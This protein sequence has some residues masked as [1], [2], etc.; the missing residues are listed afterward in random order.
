MNNDQGVIYI[1]SMHEMFYDMAVQSANSL[2]DCYN[3][4]S[5]TLFTH[6][7][8]LKKDSEIFDNI[9]THIPASARA[10]MWACARSP[11]KQTLYI[12]SDTL[13]YSDEIIK[14]FDYIDNHDIAFEKLLVGGAGNPA[15]EYAD[16][17]C[18]HRLIHHGG[19]YTWNTSD[20]LVDFFNTWYEEYHIQRYEWPEECKY[21]NEVNRKWDMLTLWRLFHEEKFK[22]FHDLKVNFLDKKFNY[23]PWTP[24]IYNPVI[25]HYPKEHFRDA[26]RNLGK[27]YEEGILK[28]QK[29]DHTAIKYY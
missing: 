7:P 14:I 12:D 22:R 24:L 20:L 11:Y 29:F 21:L 9:I 28:E 6:E 3:N 16:K 1:A 13:I 2:K 27:I 19:I 4:L 8:F 17:K 26:K 23:T 18:S 25:Y 10:K 15:W 5:V